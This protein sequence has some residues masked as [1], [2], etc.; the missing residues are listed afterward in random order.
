MSGLLV[1]A[2]SDEDGADRVLADL[3]SLE[4]RHLI[5]IDDA[6]TVVRKADGRI[7]VRQ[8]TSLDGSGALGG[9][10]WGILMGMVFFMPWIGLAVGSVRGVLAGRLDDYGISESFI[11]EV[12]AA[13][14]PGHSALF[15]LVSSVTEDKI[16]KTLAAYRATLLRQNLSQED[17]STLRD[18]FG[19]E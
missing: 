13:I 18:A 8:I 11:K 5:A 2:C 6:A 4:S 9:V 16:I 1:V 14:G 7:R 3:P 10:F 15:L 19:A 17:E 12:G